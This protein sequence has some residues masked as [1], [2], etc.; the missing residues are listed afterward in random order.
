MP[1]KLLHRARFSAAAEASARKK[2]RSGSQ[3]WSSELSNNALVPGLLGAA[4]GSWRQLSI[5]GV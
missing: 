5:V 3:E 2:I 1:S 4:A